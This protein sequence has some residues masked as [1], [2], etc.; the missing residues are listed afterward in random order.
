MN[1]EQKKELLDVKTYWN[2]WDNFHC[3]IEELELLINKFISQAIQNEREMI[4]SEL[5]DIVEKEWANP[6]NWLREFIKN[7]KTNQN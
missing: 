1:K 2:L 4:I 6:I 5:E 3:K 7:F